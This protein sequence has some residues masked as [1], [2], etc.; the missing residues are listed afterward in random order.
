MQCTAGYES[1]ARKLVGALREA[2]ESDLSDAEERE[3]TFQP[4][5]LEIAYATELG[6]HPFVQFRRKAGPAKGLV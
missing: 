6:F 1:L 3:V 2:V 4:T 5:G